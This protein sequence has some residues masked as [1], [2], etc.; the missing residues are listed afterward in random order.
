MPNTNSNITLYATY[1]GVYDD[2]QLPSGLAINTYTLIS[3]GASTD[4]IL[5]DV[6]FRNFNTSTAVLFDI[7]ICPTGSQ[8]SAQY[9]TVQISIPPNSGN[10][11]STAKASFAAIAPAEFDIDMSGNRILALK[12]GVSLY[13]QNK[14][15]LTAAINVRA[16]RRNY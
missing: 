14:A 8:L 9:N 10:N 2:V 13:V 1:D 3:S 4:S 11:G 5:T 7:I 15:A 6:L 16:K 12:S